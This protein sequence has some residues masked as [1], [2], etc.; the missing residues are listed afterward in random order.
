[1]EISDLREFLVLSRMLNFRAA[2]ESLY[3]SQS[4]LSKHV[5]SMES[6]LGVQLFVR[7]TKAVRLT[8]GGEL[9]RDAATRILDI[10]DATTEELS[11]RH[12]V[13]GKLRIAGSV[14]FPLINSRF[15]SALACF[16]KKYPDVDIEIEDIQWRN[17]RDLLLRGTYDIV[18]SICFPA[19]SEEGLVVRRLDSVPLCA[20]V[21]QSYTGDGG[22]G[23]VS[24]YDLAPLRL[25]F[26]DPSKS[27]DFVSSIRM[28]FERL[29]IKPRMGRPL[30]QM[31][32][33]GEG[34]YCLTPRFD[35][36]DY[37]GKG[38]R[39]LELEEKYVYDVVIAR[40]RN[41]A[42]P[43]SALFMEE[44]RKCSPRPESGAL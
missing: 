24:L 23:R 29:G 6:E 14:R 17:Y 39:I 34:E 33:M 36:R 37:F 44:M 13:T 41:I 4:T 15:E 21:P 38:L 3:I 30:T 42:N 28:V 26:L 27:T 32:T 11:E 25:R 7:D 12:S 9:F 1:M 5:S 31:F 8:E 10:Y 2:A 16:E 40:R 20:W 18:L 43:L 19:M 22:T 35:P